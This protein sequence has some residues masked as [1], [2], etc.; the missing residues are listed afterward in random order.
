MRKIYLL[1]GALAFLFFSC[2]KNA[3]KEVG[4]ELNTTLTAEQNNQDK[5]VFARTFA[6]ALSNP[7]VRSLLKQE[8]LKQFDHDYDVLYDVAR[9]L[10]TASGKS[11]HELIAGY[12][13]DPAAFDAIIQ[14]QPLLTIYVPKLDKFNAAGWDIAAQVPIV[15]VRNIEDAKAGKP[16]L[17][18]NAEGRQIMMSYAASGDAPVVVVKENERVTALRTGGVQG[19]MRQHSGNTY[20]FIDAAFDN[21]TGKDGSGKFREADG[22]P[23]RGGGTGDTTTYVDNSHQISSPAVR[24]AYEKRLT[25]Q[26]DYV[27]Y[28]IDPSNNIDSG[29]FKNQYA[30]HIVSIEMEDEAAL[31]KI[32]DDWTEG[33][34]EIVVNVLMLARDGAGITVKKGINCTV[35]NLKHKP[36]TPR[37]ANYRADGI[38]EY[39]LP[40]PLEIDG[41]DAYKYGDKWKFVVS[42]FDPGTET[43]T[44]TSV[45]SE[46]S[47]NFNA[48]AGVELF[49]IL[50]IGIGGGTSNKETKTTT[51]TIKSTNISDD[52]YEGILNFYTPV[53]SRITETRPGRGGS[54]PSTVILPKVYTVNTGLIR[55]R[56]EPLPRY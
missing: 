3:E 44:T 51:V 34:L 10:T 53:Y 54:G 49:G 19:N 33:N 20:K 8:A 1:T 5:T 48:N 27:Y 15:A 6:R 2:K 52:L 25:S 47:S 28:G 39:T 55:L 18:Y 13:E 22:R 37:P 26:R 7:E 14:R 41:W 24:Y 46:Y 4:P 45:S 9:E 40:N 36:G 31:K 11:L 56:I 23:V 38:L 35:D 21:I 42:E 50:K 17:A 16:L 12:A 30:E 32:T 29:R 43:T